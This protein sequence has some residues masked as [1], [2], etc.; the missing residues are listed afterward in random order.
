MVIAF[1]ER[2]VSPIK[3]GKKKHTIREDKNDLW[4][5]GNTM[6][7]ATGVRSAKYNEFHR[8]KCKNVQSIIIKKISSTPRVYSI[9][10]D[11]RELSLFDTK[12]LAMNDGFKDL[13]DFFEWFDKDFRGKILHWT[14]LKY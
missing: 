4:R 8:E 10:V 9:H 12:C 7:M 3:E 6:H 13:D 11:G 2:F 14:D 1:K 5:K